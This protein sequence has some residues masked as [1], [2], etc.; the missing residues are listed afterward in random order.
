[1]NSCPSCN[2]KFQ[3]YKPT[4]MEQKD[5]GEL[6]KCARCNTIFWRKKE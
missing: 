2:G 5:D 6:M 3:Y 1:M 4:F